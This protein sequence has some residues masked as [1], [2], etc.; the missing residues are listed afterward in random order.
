MTSIESAVTLPDDH[1]SKTA[2]YTSS[3]ALPAGWDPKLHWQTLLRGK[4]PRDLELTAFALPPTPI[5]PSAPTT[6]HASPCSSTL[7]AW[8]P[9]HFHRSTPTSLAAR[10]SLASFP[11][12]SPSSARSKSSRLQSVPAALFSFMPLDVLCTQRLS[13]L[14]PGVH[15]AP[16]TVSPGDSH[17]PSDGDASP[18]ARA[19][20]STPNTSR[21]LPPIP[22][23]VQSS[24]QSSIQSIFIPDKTLTPSSVSSS[25][26]RSSAPESPG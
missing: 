25:T 7:S 11:L 2:D 4:K 9:K 14:S 15:G 16:S 13:A 26:G 23:F 10:S 20:P 17:T 24:S 22:A 18:T 1:S 5:S 6:K 8:S 19:R 21:M 3:T 12:A